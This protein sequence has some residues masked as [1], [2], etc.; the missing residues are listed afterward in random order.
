MK[1]LYMKTIKPCFG[2][3]KSFYRT[4]IK[5]CI[6]CQFKRKC[7]LKIRGNYGINRDNGKTILI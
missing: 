3:K 7:L 1:Q 5:E 6:N 4:R 2:K